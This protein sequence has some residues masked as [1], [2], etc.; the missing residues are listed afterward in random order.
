[1]RLCEFSVFER[2]RR[3]CLH[4]QPVNEQPRFAHEMRRPLD[5]ATQLR[6]A[7]AH[8]LPGVGSCPGRRYD[9]DKP[10]RLGHHPA[11]DPTSLQLRRRPIRVGHHYL[12]RNDIQHTSAV[13]WSIDRTGTSRWIA[14][15]VSLLVLCANSPDPRVTVRYLTGAGLAGAGTER[16]WIARALVG[17]GLRDLGE[18]LR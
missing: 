5:G 18:R 8:R 9:A 2:T 10:R 1:M 6:P 17:R 13:S 14:T 15:I 7:E 16:C 3:L 12:N 11:T 4:G